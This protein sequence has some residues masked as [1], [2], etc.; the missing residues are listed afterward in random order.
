MLLKFVNFIIIAIAFIYF[1]YGVRNLHLKVE[2][3]AC[4]MTYMF[5]NPQFSVSN[6]CKI[7]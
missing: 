2:Q 7:T 1:L 3:N 6:S 4:R 5:E